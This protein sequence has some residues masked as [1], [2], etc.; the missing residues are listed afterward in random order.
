MKTLKLIR[1]LTYT[2]HGVKASRSSPL[3]KVNDETAAI[4]L[5]NG[6]F[7]AVDPPG[8]KVPAT[9]EAP[10]PRRKAKDPENGSKTVG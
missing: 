10:K 1:G 8:A 5:Q 3:V 7:I 9:P 6:F 4:L 2:G